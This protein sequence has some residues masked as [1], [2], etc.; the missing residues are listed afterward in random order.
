MIGGEYSEAG[1]RWTEISTLV[2]FL[3]ITT[4]VHEQ[5]EL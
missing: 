2:L 4:A 5:Q 1:E 3:E